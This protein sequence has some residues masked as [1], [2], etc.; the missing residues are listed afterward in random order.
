[1]QSWEKLI[2]LRST[3]A[4]GDNIG[5]RRRSCQFWQRFPRRAAAKEYST[6]F[7]L[8]SIVNTPLILIVNTPLISASLVFDAMEF[9]LGGKPGKQNPGADRACSAFWRASVSSL[10]AIYPLQHSL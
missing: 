7:T 3:A 8:L 2:R 4:G 1:L 5:D 10:P 6:A 9:A